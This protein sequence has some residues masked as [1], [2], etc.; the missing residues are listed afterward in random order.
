MEFRKIRIEEKKI[1]I[2][3]F[4]TEL[5][6]GNIMKFRKII[7]LFAAALMMAFT[8]APPAHAGGKTIWSNPDNPCNKLTLF[9]DARFRF[10]QTTDSR[11]D[12]ATTDDNED[13]MRIRLRFGAKYGTGGPMSAGFR[14]ISGGGRGTGGGSLQSPHQTLGTTNGGG[15][16]EIDRAYVKFSKAGGFIWAGK[17][18]MPIWHHTEVQW[19]T[20]IQPE[21]IAFG[22]GGEVGN[23]KLNASLGYFVLNENRW[24]KDGDDM[25]TSF[26]LDYKTSIGD[27][28]LRIGAS[29]LS[30]TE[31]D[32]TGHSL[33]TT[34]VGTDGG[35]G[36]DLDGG[37][38]SYNK[39]A[40][41]AKWNILK[42][43]AEYFIGGVDSTHRDVRCPATTDCDDTTGFVVYVRAKV[44]NMIGL[45][46]Y[47]Y[48]IGMFSMP[49]V[50]ALAQDDLPYATNWTGTR[51][52]VDLNVTKG[53]KWDIRLYNQKVK[54]DDITV[55]GAGGAMRGITGEEHTV[56]RIQTNFNVKF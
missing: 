37:S 46:V 35:K 21:G 52:Q 9:G 38:E 32:S 41:M 17:N 26:G 43:G 34:A 14:L 11:R 47:L 7:F 40:V 45:R 20:D 55:A 31:G 2:R 15:E 39:L 16:F 1:I 3:N 24:A 27:I 12:G 30:V 33:N 23:G 29:M 25:L 44:N 5:G 6:R 50:G 54:N 53:L 28:G 4:L 48:D 49:L 8:Y 13:R 22:W 36:G 10:E 19:D 56:T 51:F 18:A 42:V